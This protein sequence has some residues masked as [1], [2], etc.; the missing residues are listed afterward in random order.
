MAKL[1]KHP[2]LWG[3]FIIETNIGCFEVT[4][5][6]VKNY[7][8]ETEG[9]EQLPWDI[10]VQGVIENAQMNSSNILTPYEVSLLRLLVDVKV[11]D[12]D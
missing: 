7:L 6:Y 4:N 1:Y 5:D 12:M 3:A 2:T 11:A 10:A 9:L 8:T